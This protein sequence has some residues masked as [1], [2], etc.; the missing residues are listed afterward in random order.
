MI[1][2]EAERTHLALLE[3]WRG[4]MNLVGPGPAEVHFEDSAG[5]VADLEAVGRWVDLGSGA[6]FPGVALAARYPDVHV[7]LV[8]SRLK[9]AGFLSAVVRATGLTNL[10]VIH[11]R[12]EDVEPGF[13][14]VI[15]R[16]YRKPEA[17]L[18]DAARLLVPAG[19]AVLLTGPAPASMA[20][21]S[22]VDTQCYPVRD[23]NRTRTVLTPS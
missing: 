8:E 17:Y 15:S 16:A 14:G 10:E 13:D 21:W 23:G 2:T 11:G 9:R 1:W 5:A 4:A 22:V 7:S 12:T 6:G 19:R 20:G 18:S 3:R